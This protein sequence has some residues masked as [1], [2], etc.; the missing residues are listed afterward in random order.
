MASSW[1]DYVKKH[2]EAKPFRNKGWIHLRKFVD[3]MP[4][5]TSSTNV[6]HPSASQ[7]AARAL[8]SDIADSSDEDDE[9][10]LFNN[11]LILYSY[12][13]L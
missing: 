7:S 12:F 11:L 4:S 10:K 1:D 6:F 9:V 5:S 13:R 3:I 2:P 8:S